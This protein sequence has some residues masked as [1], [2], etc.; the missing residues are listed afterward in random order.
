MRIKTSSFCGLAR[1]DDW[2]KWLKATSEELYREL[3]KTVN[4]RK[5]CRANSNKMMDIYYSLY[6][7][8]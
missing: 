2:Q 7:K 3:M 5:G 6:Q 1:S 8:I 4:S